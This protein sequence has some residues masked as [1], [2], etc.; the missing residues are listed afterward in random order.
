MANIA[1]VN[2][3]II[4]DSAISLVNTPI[5]PYEPTITHNVGPQSRI[6]AQQVYASALY[7]FFWSFPNSGKQYPDP[8]LNVKTY[9]WAGF[10][11]GAAPV[12]TA[13]IQSYNQTSVSVNNIQAIFSNSATLI[14]NAAQASLTTISF[15]DLIY[16][17]SG[18]VSFTISGNNITTF[19][20]PELKFIAGGITI[21]AS[22]G[23]TSISFPKL[24]V[25]NGTLANSA[26]NVST[27][28]LPE[29][30]EVINFSDSQSTAVTSLSFPKLKIVGAF[31]ITGTKSSLTSISFGALE[32]ITSTITMPTT[33]ASLS[34]FTFADTLKSVNSNFV[35]TS[36][37]LNQASVDNILVRL[38]ALDGTNGTATYSN[39]TVTITG[40]SATPSA[41]GLTAK[42]TLQARGCTVTTN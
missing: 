13:T 3:N 21:P 27:Y 32:H 12:L 14:I 11:S 7:S 41:T 16:F 5:F 23:I 29:L 9:Q 2:G 22:T 20:F 24:E 1:T 4:E 40:T 42:A 18:A 25:V 19:N 6:S 17:L 33:S 30:L 37:S 36:N 26:V 39:R 35:T 28:N 10:G 31:N 34:S 38:A 15:P 8:A